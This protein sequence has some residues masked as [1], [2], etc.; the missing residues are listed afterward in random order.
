M[1]T[2]LATIGAF[3][4][5]ML[6]LGAIYPETYAVHFGRCFVPVSR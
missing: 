1:K 4:T 5:V 3:F 6:I 2:V